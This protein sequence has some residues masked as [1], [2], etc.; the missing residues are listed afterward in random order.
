MSS[1]MQVPRHCPRQ[2]PCHRPCR[3]H[4]IV[5]VDAMS[6]SNVM[7]PFNPWRSLSSQILGFGLGS[8]GFTP[9]YDYLRTS[10]I[11]LI[12]DENFSSSRRLIC[13]A[14]YNT[15][16]NSSIGGQIRSLRGHDQEQRCT[17]HLSMIHIR[18]SEPKHL[19]IEETS[20]TRK[21]N[22]NSS[23]KTQKSQE[24][25]EGNQHNHECFH[26]LEVKFITKWWRK[27][28]LMEQ[29][30]GKLSRWMVCP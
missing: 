29:G 18:K 4:V 13:D 30:D 24:L 15:F 23:K 19:G 22:E 6:L 1:S 27:S 16:W 28:M 9:I 3:C 20:R 10:W 8:M 2:V 7:C 25:Q 17:R 11:R 12:Y 14:Q 21:S 26:T 5:H